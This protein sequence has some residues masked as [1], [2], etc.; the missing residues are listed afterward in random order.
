MSLVVILFTSFIFLLLFG[1]PIAIAQGVAS[2]LVIALFNP[3]SAESFGTAM[4]MGF[5]SF[6]IVAIPLFT[7]AGDIMGRGGISKRL[8][9]CAKILCG[10]S[11]GGLGIVTVIACMVFAAISGTGSATVAAIG[12]IMIPQMV[13]ANYDKVYSTCLVSTGGAIGVLIPPSIPMVLYALSAN[14]SIT[15][16]F[17]A[18]FPVGILVGLV[19]C[20]YVF[21]TSK[22]RGYV[23]DTKRYTFKETVKVLFNAIPAILVPVIVLGG[24]YRGAFTPTEAAAIACFLGIL[25][26]VFIYKEVSFKE[27]PFLGFRSVSIGAPV[28]LIIGISYGFGRILAITQTPEIIAEGILGLTTNA[29]LLL[30]LINLL[31]LFVG[32]F[33]DSA[34]AILILTP[35]LLPIVTALGMNPVHFGLVMIL[36]LSIGFITPPLGANLF[37]ATQISNVK[38]DILAKNIW[39]WVAVMII[40][41]LIIT[42]IPEIS[43]FFPRLLGIPV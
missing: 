1:V 3:I 12:L 37:T 10:R 15:A 34:P 30:I 32:T 21:I 33:M 14:V 20:A 26:S 16:M 36:N 39:P 2:L 8:V 9:N 28:M 22:Q 7:F 24:I 19:L 31:L 4:T 13:Q 25:V 6:P 5:D 23:G 43:L 35:I 29:I 41:L 27:I 42:Y 17:T 11:T 38:F 18:G 40:V